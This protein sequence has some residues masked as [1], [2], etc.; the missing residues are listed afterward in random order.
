MDDESKESSDARMWRVIATVAGIAAALMAGWATFVRYWAASWPGGDYSSPG[1]F[2][3][4]FAPIVGL[5]T[6]LTLGA[7][8]ASVLMQRE[9]L[10]LQ[11]KEMRAQREEM[12]EAREQW[13]AQAA[14]MVEA[15]EHAAHAN[16][17]A[18]SGQMLEASRQLAELD[19]RAAD[20]FGKR[21]HFFEAQDPYASMDPL[22]MWLNY[23]ET[24]PE[25][26]TRF[27]DVLNDEVARSMAS[28][29]V[30]LARALRR[31]RD[32]EPT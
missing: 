1:T 6:S 19:L 8:L 18:H 4:S 31:L 32:T 23:Y 10:R 3:D 21:R 13:T 5:M 24:P 11:R 14:A 17:L 22:K 30:R 26:R 9:E 20:I 27:P 29:R 15:N 25:Q 28:Q 2:G 16:E 7:A 12:K